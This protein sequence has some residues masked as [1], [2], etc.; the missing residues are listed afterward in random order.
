MANQTY[1][2]PDGSIRERKARGAG[3]PADPFVGEMDA[4]LLPGHG[5]ATEATVEAVR[6]LLAGELAVAGPLT[7]TQLRA[8]ALAITGPVSVTNLPAVQPVSDGGASLT[9]DGVVGLPVDLDGSEQ[10][11]VWTLSATPGTVTSIALPDT[12]R[13]VVVTAGAADVRVRLNGDPAAAGT[14]AFAAGITVTAN[15]RRALLI[16]PGVNRTLRLRAATAS[17]VVTVGWRP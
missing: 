2:A 14:N 12:A 4:N 1:K 15:A 9:V 16:A 10:D 17:A 13:I 6:A 3:T 11:G 8:A 5:L 7:D